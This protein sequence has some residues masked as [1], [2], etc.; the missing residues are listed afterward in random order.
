MPLYSTLVTSSSW[1]DTVCESKCAVNKIWQLSVGF[2]NFEGALPPKSLPGRGLCSDMNP[3]IV[4]LRGSEGLFF[5]HIWFYTW[6]DFYTYQ[7]YC[8]GL[9]EGGFENPPQ[10][11]CKVL[12]GWT[13]GLVTVTTFTLSKTWGTLQVHCGAFQIP[14]DPDS[15]SD[16][17]KNSPP[18]PHSS[19]ILGILLLLFLFLHHL[20]GME[21]LYI[22]WGVVTL[23]VSLIKITFPNLQGVAFHSSGK[24]S[25][26]PP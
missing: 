7:R 12:W 25:N 21:D 19:V 10:S 26:S 16:K 18:L 22:N 8:H 1:A 5:V 24:H 3:R 9:G 20:K 14:P 11:T 4:A 17:Y 23:W 13:S 2:S 6:S 15:T